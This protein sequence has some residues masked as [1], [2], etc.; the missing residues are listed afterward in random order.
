MPSTRRTGPS[1]TCSGRI[2]SGNDPGDGGERGEPDA[3]VNHPPQGRRDAGTS[4]ATGTGADATVGSGGSGDASVAS[5]VAVQPRGKLDAAQQAALIAGT[6]AE[7]C[8]GYDAR[9]LIPSLAYERRGASWI[10]CANAAPDCDALLDCPLLQ[11]RRPSF[12]A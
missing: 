10:E 5:P 3:A 11:C 8:A 9:G 4:G 2:E 6:R 1:S 12:S 7:W